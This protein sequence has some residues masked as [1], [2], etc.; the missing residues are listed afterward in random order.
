MHCIEEH[1]RR[2][3]LRVRMPGLLSEAVFADSAAGVA[4]N[5]H[6]IREI[7]LQ[8]ILEASGIFRGS[9]GSQTNATIAGQTL[10][11]KPVKLGDFYGAPPTKDVSGWSASAAVV[12][13]SAKQ[14]AVIISYRRAEQICRL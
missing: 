6:R 4:R 12:Q 1:P 3:G 2:E 14:G 7:A 11:Y 9:R 8:R 10:V 13:M 5:L